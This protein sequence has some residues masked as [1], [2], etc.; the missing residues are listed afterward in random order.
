MQEGD[1]FKVIINGKYVAY[2]AIL[3][4]DVAEV[5]AGL[6][7]ELE[8]SDIPEFQEFT[9]TDETTHVLMT[10]AV[11][12]VPHVVTTSTTNGGTFPV[13]IVT[14]R[15]GSA[16]E[17]EIQEVRLG[18]A[19]TGGTFTLTFQ[20]QTTGAMAY[21]I[22]AAAMTTALEAMSNIAPG[23]VI[24]TRSGS[25]TLANP[26]VWSVEFDAT[27]GNLDV[28]LM[29][30][31]GS[32]ITGA[33][34][35]NV[36]ST[37]PGGPTAN[38]VQR[39]TVLFTGNADTEYTLSLDH[40][41][42]GDFQILSGGYFTSAADME[43][44]ISLALSIY[45]GYVSVTQGL[46]S[47][48]GGSTTKTY[49]VT[50]YGTYGGIDLPDMVGAIVGTEVSSLGIAE[51]TA[52]GA[53][54]GN[55]VQVVT[56][57]GGPTGGTFT[58]SFAGQTTGAIAYN[59]SAAT[60][61]TAL[62]ALSNIDVAD[63][64]V[65]GSAGGPYTCTFGGVYAGLDVPLMTVSGASLTGCSVSVIVTNEAVA[66]VNEL[67]SI[68][69][70]NTPTGGTFTLT[71]NAETTGAIAYNATAATVQTALEGLATPVPGDVDVSGAA[72]GPW[73]VEFKAAYASTNVAAMTGSGASLTGGGTQTLTAT[74]SIVA[75]GKNFADN[76]AN[77]STGS[78]P[79]NSDTLIFQ[80]SEIDV[81]YNLEA[82]TAVTIT[83]LYVYQ[84][85]TGKIGLPRWNEQGYVEYR[86]QK[87]KL[88]IT[89]I[90]IGDGNGAGS[91]RIN[92]NSQAT[93]TTILVNNSGSPIDDE[94]PAIQWIGTHA[95]NAAT[96]N[97]GNFG[98]AA[99]DGEAATLATLNIGFVESV[100]SDAT[101]VIGRGVTLAAVNAN[102]GS[103]LINCA[104]TGTV[105]ALAGEVTLN[106]TGAVAQLT[107]RG[108]AVCRYCTS[109]TLGGATEVSDSAVLDFSRDTRS[110]T[111]TNPIDCYGPLTR[112]VDPNK[113]TG[114]VV[115]DFNGFGQN[116][117]LEL[118]RNIRVTR[119]T[120]A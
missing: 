78:L 13:E 60:V 110:K 46:T 14:T 107:L 114:S 97:R 43:L 26:Y 67:Q 37:T 59:A 34:S 50:F 61:E 116:K 76:T 92:I 71:F 85:Y 120:P 63:I 103:T 19:P 54:A 104:T 109:G 84:S 32:S 83:N 117:E 106:G 88:G 24:V 7:V 47:I 10:A 5:V 112:I 87:L 65:T 33:C 35:G 66:A 11:K 82:L 38:E 21:N 64:A 16:G 49:D 18:G 20:G 105:L 58:I 101:V 51:V 45:G 53:A 36:S 73:L 111:V 108:E 31:S 57:I 99:I 25:G 42:Y 70:A 91:G 113:V 17:N 98:A 2:T 77:Y 39:I 23:D 28:Q 48:S 15:E 94:L 3:G 75:T 96:I 40:P 55:E 79:V 72:G 8:A 90:Y 4:D 9:Y 119:G 52:G 12:G 115:V 22:S 118:G 69:L 89:N 27:Y 86:A 68:T 41:T 29:T 44:A 1:I 81:L 93:Q 100:D 95:S 56:I 74:N 30:G 102:G 80:D 6:I 62:E